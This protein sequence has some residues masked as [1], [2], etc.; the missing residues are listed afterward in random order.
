MDGDSLT[1]LDPA[2][3]QGNSLAQETALHQIAPYIGKMKSTK[4]RALVEAYSQPGDRILD[5]F[6]GSGG[7]ALECVLAGRGIIAC[8]VNPYAVLLTKA[9]L[10]APPTVDEALSKA[11]CYLER[12]QRTAHA[13]SLDRVPAWVRRFFHRRTLREVIALVSVLR[14]NREYFLLACLLGIL[15]HQRPG[16][17]SFPASHLVPYLRTEKFPRR[18]YP[19][20]YAYRAIGPRL[21][22]KIFRA[23]RR[24]PEID[25]AIPWKCERRSAAN[26]HLPKESVQAVVTS[27]P[28]MNALDYVGDNRL[29]LWFLGVA[30]HANQNH[31]ARYSKVRFLKL[32]RKS[33]ICIHHALSSNGKC[34]IVLGDVRGPRGPTDTAELVTRIAVDEVGGFRYLGMIEDSIPDI[35]RARKEGRCTKRE[36]VVVL[37]RCR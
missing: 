21:E 3:W 23:Y 1:T 12:A 18:R 6:V 24:F 14:R 2:A 35:R 25:P 13:I 4:A 19:E 36:W 29:R 16:F 37:Q 32:M 8:D 17:L 5:P 22:R 15:H 33:L 34:V 28:Y 20:L 26:L 31:N 27:P 9:K 7:I 30:E 10:S 11:S